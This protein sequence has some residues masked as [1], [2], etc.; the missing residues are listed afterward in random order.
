M[1]SIATLHQAARRYCIER[2]SYWQDSGNSSSDDVRPWP[3]EILEFLLS[4]VE[5]FVPM[6]FATSDE[7]RERLVAAARTPC[8]GVLETAA[9]SH[10]RTLFAEFLLRGD[11]HQWAHLPQLPYRRTLGDAE[12]KRLRHSLEARWGLWYGGYCDRQAPPVATLDIAIMETPGAYDCLRQA[13]SAQNEGQRLF[14]LRE[15]SPSYELEVADT[16]FQAAEGFWVGRSLDWMVYV[17]HEASVTFA[18][19]HLID[20]MRSLPEFEAHLYREC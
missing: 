17:S 14:E 3:W 18:G 6:D 16:A 8:S 10:E 1:D 15:Y 9:I 4:E 2:V 19:Q 5:K 13:V 7:L 11:T 12:I 20:S